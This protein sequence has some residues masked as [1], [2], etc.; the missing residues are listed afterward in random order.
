MKYFGENSE[1]LNK[2][3]SDKVHSKDKVWAKYLGVWTLLN[4]D[5]L[6]T[7]EKCLRYLYN[8]LFIFES[9]KSYEVI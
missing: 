8:S 1:V 2:N 7:S 4:V 3:N 5:Y 6:N 9:S